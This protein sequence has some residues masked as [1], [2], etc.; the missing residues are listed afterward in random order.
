MAKKTLKQ[1]LEA[2]EQDPKLQKL[3]AELSQ[4]VK[5]S[6][7]VVSQN[8]SKW[9]AHNDIY[10]GIRPLDEEDREA[11]ERDEP[12]KMTVPMTFAQVNTFVSFAFLLLTQKRRFYEYVATGAEDHGYIN[13]IE[14]ILERDLRRNFWNQLLFQSLLDTTRFGVGIVK[15]WWDIEK[16]FMPIQ[17]NTESY[18]SGMYDFSTAPNIEFK[19]F[20]KF[21]GNKM[22]NVSPYN[23]FYDTRFPISDWRKGNFVAD[24]TEWHINDLKKWE[25]AGV[26]YGVDH[27][28]PMESKNFTARGNTRLEGLAKFADSSGK[29]KDDQIVVLTEVHKRII[30]KNYDLGDFEHPM[31]YVFSIANDNRILNARP[32]SYVHDDWCYDV[33]LF[34]PDQHQKLAIG[35]SDTIYAMQDVISFLVNSRLTSVRRSLEHNAVVDPA[36]ID[37]A[38][39]RNNEPYIT[40]K[41]L[42]HNQP[43]SNY[44]QQLPYVDTTT[45]NLADAEMLTR[46]MNI[47]TGVNENA[48][49]VVSSGRRSATELRAA[50]G[51]AAARMKLTTAL[52]WTN[53]FSP[54]GRKLQL[55]S[56]QGLSEASFV[57]ILGASAQP[58][59]Q[60]FHPQSIGD[61]V[62]SEDH[63]TY[64]GTVESE[65]G[66]TA[67]NLQE[68]L[69]VV[70]SSPEIASMIQ[71]DPTKIIEEIFLLRGID[72]IERFRHGQ[73]TNQ[74]SGPLAGNGPV[75][76]GGMPSNTGGI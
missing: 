54:L 68:L 12:V 33:G 69:S 64:D 16:Q 14:E 38:S 35:L 75:G 27:I 62:G 29:D 17:S 50:N 40:T 23:F 72:N 41:K 1:R 30:P 21:E 8:Y 24:E 51:G 20:V 70:L 26:Y 57:K 22:L 58:R 56:R 11:Q 6:R 65:K 32:M 42:G 19:E 5:N 18:S 28:E 2:K 60:Q 37:M 25:R 55:N 59:F 4:D 10:R 36:K 71:I 31:P 46:T 43:I 44:F 66:Y 61:L 3:L 15:S 34:S 9:D 52:L 74:P 45:A 48:Q 13:D 49:G 63:F 7:S 53:Q 76:V 73:Q 67:Q 47:I 39:L